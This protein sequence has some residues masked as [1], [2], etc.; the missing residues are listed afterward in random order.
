MNT[1]SSWR[2]SEGPCK[3]RHEGEPKRACS[4]EKLASFIAT[5]TII[6]IMD[7]DYS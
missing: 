5:Y 6:L 4:E 2:S 1:E 7:F 3:G